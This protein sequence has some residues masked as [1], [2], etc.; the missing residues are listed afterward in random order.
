MF[1]KIGDGKL[2]RFQTDC[3]TE[4]ED[5]EPQENS[6]K[7]GG[8]S[9]SKNA[10]RVIAHDESLND[11]FNFNNQ[12]QGIHDEISSSNRDDSFSKS[13]KFSYSPKG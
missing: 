1:L 8:G 5:A 12:Y 9:S 3:L 6:G 10:R 13:S 2:S 4:C 7:T 11:E